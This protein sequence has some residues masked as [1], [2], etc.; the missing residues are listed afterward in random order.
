[1]KIRTFPVLVAAV[2]VST[3]AGSQAAEPVSPQALMSKLN[4]RCIGP[5]IGGRVV[6]V[7]G[8]RGNKNLFY[9]GTVGGGLWKSANGSEW[10]NI[11]DGKLPGPSSS[12]GAVAVAA[13]DPKIIYVGT[14]EAD[15]RA[16]VIPG[17][18]VFK[19]TDEGKT[20]QYAGLRDAHSI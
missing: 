11:T 14:G 20:W 13:S 3:L 18:G 12:I 7:T 10:E 9:A 6:T 1:M 5:Y 19:S 2:F 16:N 17:D 4:W 8:V 15:I